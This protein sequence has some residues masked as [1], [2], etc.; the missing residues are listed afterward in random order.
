MR[1]VGKKESE[2]SDNMKH[3]QEWGDMGAFMYLW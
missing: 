2:K 1:E 3:W